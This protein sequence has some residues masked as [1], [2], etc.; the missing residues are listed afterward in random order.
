MLLRLS[1]LILANSHAWYIIAIVIFY[2]AFYL[3]FKYIKNEKAAFTLMGIF[4]Y[5]TVSLLLGHSQE[6]LWLHGE[7][8]FNTCP[9]LFVGMLV[10]KFE[11]IIVNFVKKKY[12]IILIVFILLFVLFFAASLYTLYTLSKYSYWAELKGGS[13]IPERWICLAFQVPAIVFFVFTVFTLG[14][15]LKC[16]GPVLKFLG[17]MTL[18]LYL[19]HNLLIGLFVDFIPIKS[20]ILYVYLVLLFSILTAYSVKKLDDFLIKILNKKFRG[21]QHEKVPFN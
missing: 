14:L 4:C 13:G 1:G 3:I 9:L 16:S 17:T 18:E 21:V 11:D 8:W 6:N 2:I 20:D 19:I 10:A 15:K 12:S 7:W 5:I